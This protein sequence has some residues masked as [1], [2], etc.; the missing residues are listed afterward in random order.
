MLLFPNL[1]YLDA[2][3]MVVDHNR[4]E[5]FRVAEEGHIPIKAAVNSY[6]FTF[7]TVTLEE[8]NSQVREAGTRI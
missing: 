1:P 4:D 3:V 2:K 6:T 8:H 7:Y 5:R